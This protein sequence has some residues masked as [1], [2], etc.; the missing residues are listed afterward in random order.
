METRVINGTLHTC[1]NASD[2]R[3]SDDPVRIT[4]SLGVSGQA[5]G[6]EGSWDKN[7][8]V[9]GERQKDPVEEIRRV[10]FIRAR[11]PTAPRGDRLTIGHRHATDV[12]SARFRFNLSP[13]T[14]FIPPNN[15]RQQ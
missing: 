2:E 12:R 13:S 8:A 9:R 6:D 1:S 7:E 14:H 15:R 5:H 3:N 10:D 4:R 11:L